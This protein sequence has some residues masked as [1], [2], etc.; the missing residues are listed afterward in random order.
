MVM[1]ILFL[2]IYLALYPM[3][4]SLSIT[5]TF[6]QAL[7]TFSSWILGSKF[8][9]FV[10]PYSLFPPLSVWQLSPPTFLSCDLDR[11]HNLGDTNNH[12][13]ALQTNAGDLMGKPKHVIYH[14]YC[15]LR[16][17]SALYSTQEYE[18]GYFLK[19]LAHEL[20]WKLGSLQVFWWPTCVNLYILLI[21]YLPEGC[22][23]L[24]DHCELVGVFGIVVQFSIFHVIPSL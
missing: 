18:H 2:V 16:F 24:T 15:H 8:E 21:V 9:I 6:N 22:H 11:L 13:L 17:S 3:Y 10:L 20:C 12:D 23:D 7:Y 5:L 14:F 4:P 19:I 1:L